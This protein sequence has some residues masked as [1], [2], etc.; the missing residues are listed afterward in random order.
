MVG[1]DRHA[2]AMVRTSRIAP[3][4]ARMSCRQLALSVKGDARNDLR[5]ATGVLPGNWMWDRRV[6]D[7]LIR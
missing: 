1:N 6:V 5:L 4:L 3:G 2:V 7:P